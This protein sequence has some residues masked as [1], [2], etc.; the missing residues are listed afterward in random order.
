MVNGVQVN[1]KDLPSRGVQYPDDIEIFVKPMTVRE[2][3]ATNLERFGVT[4]ASYYDNLLQSIEIKGNFDKNKLL[5]GDIQCLDLIR[6]LFTF[7]LKESVTVKGELCAHC[8]KELKVSFMFANNGECKHWVQFEDYKEG[9]F[10]KEYEFLDGLKIKVSPAII[11]DVIRILKKY[12]SNMKSEDDMI[13]CALACR[14]SNVTAIDGKQFESTESMQNFLIKY[15][16]DLYKYKDLQ[17][18]EK[19]DEETSIVVKP[20]N[21][22]C[23]HCLETT[24]VVLEPSMRFHQE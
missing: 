19:I 20:F 14:A 9:I 2:E 24:E 3:M 22:E 11:G 5:L 15:M 17:L 13:D 4:K 6:R 23:G 16:K 10:D 8:G 12:L 21:I 7:E 1:I 18:L